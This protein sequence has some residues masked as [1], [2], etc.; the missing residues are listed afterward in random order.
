MNTETHLTSKHTGHLFTQVSLQIFVLSC[1]CHFYCFRP[2]RFSLPPLFL[3]FNLYFAPPNPLR[4]SHQ[5]ESVTETSRPVLLFHRVSVSISS[6]FHSEF[7]CLVLVS[8]VVL[9]LCRRV[10]WF[11]D[12]LPSSWTNPV[13]NVL[14]SLLLHPPWTPCCGASHLPLKPRGDYYLSH[15]H[16]RSTYIIPL[17]VFSPPSSLFSTI[18]SFRHGFFFGAPEPRPFLFPSRFFA[19]CRMSSS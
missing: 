19:D 5:S 18:P 10:P 6:R 2:Q 3:I 9:C 8:L 14:T 16:K 12:F 17:V 7:G 11:F 4:S 13:N 1:Q 15:L